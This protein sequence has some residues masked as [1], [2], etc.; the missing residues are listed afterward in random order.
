MAENYKQYIEHSPTALFVADPE[1]NYIFVNKAATE[2]VDYSKEELLNMSIVDMI[3]K[4]DLEK[5][6]KDFMEAKKTGRLNKEYVLKAK[7]DSAVD[8]QLN[9]IVLD[10]GNTMA[11]CE[12]ISHLKEVERKLEKKLQEMQKVNDIMVGREVKMTE[13]KEKIKSLE[14]QLN[15]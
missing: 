1:G 14:K 3:F 10:N 2:L 13:L 5:T 12:N 9:A 8:V 6:M 11:F 4:K 7:D 15:K